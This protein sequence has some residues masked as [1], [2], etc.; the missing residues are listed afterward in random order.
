VLVGDY[1]VPIYAQWKFGKGMVGSFMCDLNGTWSSDLITSDSGK[2]LILNMV[3]ALMP[4]EEI[5]PNEFNVEIK[6]GNYI[7]QLSVYADLDEGERIEGTIS[8]VDG[9][10]N[11]SLNSVEQ[12]EENTSDE[13]YITVALSATNNY[14][15]STFIIK[16]AGIYQVT[17]NK[18]N[19]AGEV[20]A[21][22]QTYK[23]F[24]YSEEYNIALEQTE[25]DIIASMYSLAE[26]GNGNV[27]VDL[28][29][30]LEIFENFV[31]AINM[32]YD[33]T[34]IL[35]IIAICLFL[36]DVAVRKFKFK[37]IHELIA[38]YRNKKSSNQ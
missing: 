36:L 32:T 30:P 24:S 22:Y 23:Q 9:N 35:I 19:A 10:I 12:T 28:E 18:L 7:N 33:P 14:S 29:N 17:L 2:Q 34:M 5:K 6:E 13:C 20:L 21:T 11:I 1:N 38:D 16:R 25:T 27:I 26:K 31:T 8:S 4:M 3:N 15:R 37:W